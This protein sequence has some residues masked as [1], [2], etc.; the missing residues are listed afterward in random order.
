M[1]K[2]FS[3]LRDSSGVDRFLRMFLEYLESIQRVY[4]FLIFAA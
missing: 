3:V 2:R 4:G 1:G